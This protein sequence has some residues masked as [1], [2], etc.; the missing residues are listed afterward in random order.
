MNIQKAISE[1]RDNLPLYE[2]YVLKLA[3]LF[4]EILTSEK[5]DHVIEYRVKDIADFEE[6]ISREGK[7]YSDPLNQITDICGIRIITSRTRFLD[8]IIRILKKEPCLSGCY[9]Q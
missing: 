9:P 3:A 7:S 2:G 4:K 8:D 1:Y 6:K 5:I